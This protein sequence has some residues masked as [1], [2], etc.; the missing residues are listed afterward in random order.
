MKMNEL[1]TL[2][3]VAAFLK[4]SKKTAYRM[5]IRWKVPIVRDGRFVRIEK[6]TLLK[7]LADKR[8]GY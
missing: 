4:V 7:A 1:L 5:L 6:E 2:K 3:Q 8:G